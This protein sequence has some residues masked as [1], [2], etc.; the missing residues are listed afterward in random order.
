MA[1]KRR[2]NQPNKSAVTKA[3][4]KRGDTVYVLT[5]SSKGKTGVV[6]KVI[7]ET[8]KAIVEGMNIKKKATKPNP[9]AGVAGGIIESEAPIALS[10]LMV[11]DHTVSKPTR[12]RKETVKSDDGKE[13]RVRVSVK[14]GKTIDDE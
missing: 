1:T 4:I 12:T 8:G 2:T 5:G 13:R 6:K 7:L 3:H 14:S 9:M 11:F 10:N